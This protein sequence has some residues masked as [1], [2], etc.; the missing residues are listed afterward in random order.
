MQKNEYY[1]VY[2]IPTFS[3]IAQYIIIFLIN[4]VNWY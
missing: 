3:D 2:A 4:C 1:F